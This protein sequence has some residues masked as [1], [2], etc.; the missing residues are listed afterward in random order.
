MPG[1]VNRVFQT[2]ILEVTKIFL[3]RKAAEKLR[4]NHQGGNSV[5]LTGQST[6]NSGG[7]PIENF[8]AIVQ[9][10]HVET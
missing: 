9:T 8:N 4:H 5:N 10:E 6:L 3:E 1:N 7:K 2:D